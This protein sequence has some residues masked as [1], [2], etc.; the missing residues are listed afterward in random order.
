VSC[1]LRHSSTRGGGDSNEPHLTRI[2]GF[3][4]L[5]PEG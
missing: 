2:A 1:H 3:F 4:F 5:P